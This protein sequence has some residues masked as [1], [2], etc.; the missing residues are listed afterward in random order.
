MPC[1]SRRSNGSSTVT[2]PSSR[3]SL[4]KK[5]AYKR[6]RIACS[7]PPMY[8]STAPQI[9]GFCRYHAFCELGRHVAEEIPARFHEGVHGVGFAFCRATAAGRWFRKLRHFASG[10][11]C[12][13][14][15]V[16]R[17]NDGQLV[18]RDGDVAAFFR[19]GRWGIGSPIV[20]LARNTD[21][22]RAGGIGF[23]VR[24]R[25]GFAA[26]RRWRRRPSENSA[27]S[28]SPLLTNTPFSLSP[29]HFLPLVCVDGAVADGNDL[30]FRQIVLG[31]K[32]K[33]RSSCAGTAIHCAVAVAPQY[34]VGNPHLA[35]RR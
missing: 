24:P 30:F 22:S 14:H 16:F 19:N 29:Y 27:P 5:R 32:L 4:V 34:I 23:S 13:R 17:Q 21:P 1:V 15:D 2:K 11:P 12:R 26:W 9:F 31:G 25:L 3:I 7:I 20:A 33:S 35:C 8:W 18:G 28:K 10:E 6:C